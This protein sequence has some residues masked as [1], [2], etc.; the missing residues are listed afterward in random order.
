MLHVHEL[1]GLGAPSPRWTHVLVICLPAWMHTLTTCLPA[2][3]VTGTALKF[4]T[5][6]GTCYLNSAADK[7]D[8]PLCDR[9]ALNIQGGLYL[10]WAYGD[11]PFLDLP[12]LISSLASLEDTCGGGPP[13]LPFPFEQFFGRQG[14]TTPNQNA[15]ARKAETK[16]DSV[17]L[18][19]FAK[20]FEMGEPILT[21]RPPSEAQTFKKLTKAGSTAKQAP[22]QAQAQA[23]SASYQKSDKLYGGLAIIISG[24]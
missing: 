18:Q 17:L 6:W 10:S 12:S 2:A 24:E 16:P 8:S 13:V 7:C 15:S 14:A 22:A 4:G 11:V 1:L 20:M 23:A 5:A 3:S 21:G 9:M 19:T